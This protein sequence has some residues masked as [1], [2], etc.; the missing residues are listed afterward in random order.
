[1]ADVLKAFDE[2]LDT[3]LSESKDFT[4]EA[5]ANISREPLNLVAVLA[6]SLDARG[7]LLDVAFLTETM[8]QGDPETLE[9][10]RNLVDLDL[11]LRR[12]SIACLVAAILDQVREDPVLQEEFRFRLRTATST[13]AP[14]QGDKR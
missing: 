1:M 9:Q 3:Q 8:K 10:L 4:R 7:S 13:P 11:N 14:A 5:V 2:D 6:M 12:I